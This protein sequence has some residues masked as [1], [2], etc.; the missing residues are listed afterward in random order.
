MPTKAK[1]AELTA[2]AQEMLLEDGVNSPIGLRYRI[3]PGFVLR[4]DSARSV[5]VQNFTTGFQSRLD[6]FESFSAGR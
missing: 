1:D 5:S 4:F 2:L 6:A 3:V